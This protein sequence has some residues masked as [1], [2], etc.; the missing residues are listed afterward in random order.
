MLPGLRR[1]ALDSTILDDAVAR[2]D[3]VTQLIARDLGIPP[4]TVHSRMKNIRELFGDAIKGPTQRLELIIALQATLPRW[5]A[6]ASGTG[7]PAD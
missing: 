2:Q 1:S 7:S 5:R 3:T 6:E 4:Q